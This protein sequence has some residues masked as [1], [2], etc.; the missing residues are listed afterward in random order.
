[1][2]QI[3]NTKPAIVKRFSKKF[4]CLQ[5]EADPEGRDVLWPHGCTH[6]R[7]IVGFVKKT[8]CS[9]R[10]SFWSYASVQVARTGFRGFCRDWVRWHLFVVR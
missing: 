10:G 8:G 3:L 9:L 6:Y 5:A 1:M 4:V 7:V 2:P